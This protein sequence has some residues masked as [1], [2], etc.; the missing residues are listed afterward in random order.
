M[1]V[2]ISGDCL[3][4]LPAGQPLRADQALLAAAARTDADVTTLPTATLGGAA[5]AAL[6]RWDRS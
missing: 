4:A 6:L 5:V 2:V 3:V 1:P